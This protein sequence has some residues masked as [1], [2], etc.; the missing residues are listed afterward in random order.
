MSI[1]SEIAKMAASAKSESR[2]MATVLRTDQ[3]GTVWVS[4][5]GGAD[6]TFLRGSNVEMRPGD[7]VEVT[8]ADGRATATGNVTSPSVGM[9]SVREAVQPVAESA[10]RALEASEAA[11]E[12]AREAGEA[13][14]ATDQHFWSRSTDPDQDGAGTGAF[15]T[16]AEREDFLAAAAQGFPDIGEGEGKRPWHNILMNSLG[17]LLRSGLYDLASLTRSGIAFYDGD[18]NQAGN[19]L[20]LFGK[21]GAQVGPD[22]GSHVSISSNS[23][24]MADAE[25]KLLTIYFDGLVNVL[26]SGGN[27]SVNPYGEQDLKNIAAMLNTGYTVSND[28]VIDP[29]GE[30]TL[31]TVDGDAVRNRYGELIHSAHRYIY[32]NSSSGSF[33]LAT[34]MTPQVDEE[35][36]PTVISFGDSSIIAK[37]EKLTVAADG[38]SI[39]QLCEASG[40]GSFAIGNNAKATAWGAYAVGTNAKASDLF[41][42]AEGS[43]TAASGRYSRAQNWGTIA[44]SEAQTALGRYNIKDQNGS[45]AVIVGNGTDANNRSNC[46]A[47][48]WDTRTWVVIDPSSQSQ[49]LT[50]NASANSGVEVGTDDDNG[51]AYV[52]AVQLC[53]K[54]G[55]W[56]GRY[57]A[58]SQNGSNYAFL[59]VRNRKADGTDVTNYINLIVDKDGST[60]YGMTSPRAFRE[61]L[62][63]GQ[64]EEASKSSVSVSS[65][66]WANVVT[67]S[68]PAGVWLVNARVSYPANSTGTRWAK[69]STT[70]Q[71][72]TNNISVVNQNA[73]SAGTVHMHT[74]RVFTLTATKT[75]YLLGY[76]NS[77]AAL[78][79]SG[80]IEAS[81]IG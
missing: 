12:L 2:H 49:F 30:T 67:L 52:G 63:L 31:Y 71:D 57:G 53:D 22:G 21:D 33:E 3:D 9:R 47:I 56:M 27:P 10:T 73:N 26:N 39:G 59:G 14:T 41:A 45:Y 24:T 75:V 69:L 55:Y 32:Y 38:A 19:V 5:A 61:C 81:R 16:D 65:G 13:A 62:S 50:M 48:G 40:A 4:I 7:Q 64:L 43:D 36:I 23:L 58:R 72:S 8:I 68:L 20:A 70:S 17:I 78:S 76:Q 79:C 54:N 60:R 34:L 80:A 11:A 28:K 35:V 77:G 1:A 44:A 66:S 15:V 74:T 18:G 6:E 51:N 46:L 25:R 42:Y 29:E 37:D